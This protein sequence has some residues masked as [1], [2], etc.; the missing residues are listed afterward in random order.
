[1][2]IGI[3]GLGDGTVEKDDRWMLYRKSNPAD[4]LYDS[5]Y[6]SQTL[7]RWNKTL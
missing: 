5:Q 2:V 1:M 6:F 3:D 7:Q 4:P